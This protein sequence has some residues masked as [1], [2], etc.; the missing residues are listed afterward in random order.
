MSKKMT[1]SNSETLSYVRGWTEPTFHQGKEVF[2]SFY[3][4]DPN[5]G[6]L[7]RKKIM[8]GRIK[9]KAAQRQ[10]ARRII[11]RV[12]ERLLSGWNPWIEQS[13]PVE[14]TTF[15][16]V[17]ERY[18][19]YL[20]KLVKDD[21]MREESLASYL[22]YLRVLERWASD[23]GLQY[24][25][26]LDRHRVGEFLDYVFIERN[27]TLQTR[28]NYLA[29]LKTFS[30]WLLQRTYLNADPTAGMMMVQRRAKKKNRSVIPN[31]VLTRVREYLYKNNRHFLLACYLLHYLFIRPHEMTFLTIGDIRPSSQTLLLHG[32]NTKNRNDAVITLPAKVIRLMLELEVFRFPSHYYLFSDGF[33]PGRERKSEKMFR[34]YW[35]RCVRKDLDLPEQYKFY[36]LK[37]TGITNMLRANHDVLTVRDQARHSSILITDTYTPKD[38]Q[39]A[40][41]A[42]KNYDGF[43]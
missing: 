31:D 23:Q 3:A 41:E 1:F 25:F 42:L 15:A 14:Y 40:N 21:D 22:S 28:N 19:E 26:Q 2:V 4:F 36:S 34:D 27:N 35:T 6:K 5:I 33:K 30:R 18:R 29:W 16:V 9:G 10:H 13:S 8:L 37:D 20:H 11:E 12:K 39:A 24:I 7:H 17:A 32:E 43:L 38:I